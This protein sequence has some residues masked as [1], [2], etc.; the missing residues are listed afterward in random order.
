MNK[1]YRANNYYGMYNKIRFQHT[2]NLTEAKF[3]VTIVHVK[4]SNIYEKKLDIFDFNISIFQ[5]LVNQFLL[6]KRAKNLKLILTHTN[7]N[8]RVKITH[9]NSNS[10]SF[11]NLI[12]HSYSFSVYQFIYPLILKI[13]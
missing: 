11:T 1:I 9:I 3:T 2:S 8:N 10:N 4:N 7:Y 12:N 13:L 6:L 5:F